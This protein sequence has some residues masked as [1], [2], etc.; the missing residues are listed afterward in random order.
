VLSF[1]ISAFKVP[2]VF[3]SSA[4]NFMS[5]SS[6]LQPSPLD[7]F[8]AG[9]AAPSALDDFSAGLAAPPAL[10]DFSAGLAAAPALDRFLAALAAPSALD[11]FSAGLAAP[12]ALD[13]LSAALAA[14]AALDLFLDR[15]VTAFFLF[16]VFLE[17]FLFLDP[18]VRAY[19]CVT[20]LKMLPSAYDIW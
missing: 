2:I 9:S 5:L 17:D 19:F 10:D 1:F 16:F 18:P 20:I 11:G 6:P 13:R 3:L 14:P 8:P 4:T 15:F 7:D 12:P